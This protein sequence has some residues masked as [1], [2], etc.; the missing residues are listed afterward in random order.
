MMETYKEWVK[1]KA[2]E[3]AKHRELLKM[4]EKA[5]N[6]KEQQTL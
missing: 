4:A 3:E 2:K 6:D 5:M 1:R